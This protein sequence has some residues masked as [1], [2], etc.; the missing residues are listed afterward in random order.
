M[1]PGGARL[2][3]ILLLGRLRGLARAAVTAISHLCTTL[4]EWY[5]GNGALFALAWPFVSLPRAR[6]AAV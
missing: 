6:H 3:G 5:I 4:T 1:H 2:L